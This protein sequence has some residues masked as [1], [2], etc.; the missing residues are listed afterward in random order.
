MRQLPWIIAIAFV[1]AG[2]GASPAL[3]FH[4]GGVASCARCHVMH[5]E[6]DGDVVIEGAEPLLVAASAT[7]VC[8]TCHGGSTGVFGLDPLSPPPERG[9]GNFVFLLEDNLNDAPD[10]ATHPIAGEAAGHSIVSLDRGVTADSR[11][12]HSPGGSFPSAELGCTSCHDPHGNGNFRMLNGAGEVQGGVFRFFEAAP[13]AAGLDCAAPGVAE[14]P[15]A[16]TAYRAGVSDWCANCHGNN[17]H[18]SDASTFE[19]PSEESLGEMARRYDRYDGDSNPQGGSH[20][21]AYLP[22]VPF[23]DP[24]AVVNSS[25]GPNSSSRVMCLTCHRAH[26]S[27]A[28]A[29]G[30]WDFNVQRLARDGVIS[31]S[32]PLPNPYHDAAQG[33]LC[34]KC[35]SHP[36]TRNSDSP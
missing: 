7:D 20:A 12:T 6:R 31:G 8:L 9:A 13:I 4:D 28:P 16:H 22:E 33:S 35:H 11:W 36:P 2:V 34:A 30:R 24:A 23:Q 5:G 25:V 18:D 19:H 14:S 21:T 15:G 17:F 27:S 3:A 29:A 26:G 10:G 1:T 32:Y